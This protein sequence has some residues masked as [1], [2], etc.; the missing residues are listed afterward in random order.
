MLLPIVAAF[1]GIHSWME[2]ISDDS[3]Y[4]RETGGST[5]MGTV[6]IAAKKKTR[7]PVKKCKDAKKKLE[8]YKLEDQV[9]KEIGLLPL[10]L[11]ERLEEGKVISW[12]GR[13][14]EKGIYFIV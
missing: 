13:G 7:R 2:S 8:G 12:L 4:C 1:I 3:Y 6:S 5:V 11:R 9:T 10:W 14:K